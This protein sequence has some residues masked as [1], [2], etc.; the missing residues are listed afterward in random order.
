MPVRLVARAAAVGFLALS[1]FQ[2]AL[3]VGAP[4]AHLAWG[5]R[6]EGV[7]PVGL[8]LASAAAVVFLL[9]AAVLVTVAARPLAEGDGRVALARRLAGVL[10]FLLL[11]NAAGNLVS[12][13][14][15]ERVV[16]TP[17]AG[18]LAILTGLVAWGP[19]RAPVVAEPR[20]PRSARGEERRAAER[21]RKKQQRRP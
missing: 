11:L 20:P 21:R 3:A 5:G 6:H 14:N 18:V 16:M 19:R 12:Q 17:A 9:G 7:L 13:S 2:A 4:W 15:A 8:R 1:A 10:A